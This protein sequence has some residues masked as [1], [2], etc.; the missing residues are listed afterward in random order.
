[1]WGQAEIVDS[2]MWGQAEIVDSTMWGQA[3][4]VDSFIVG[5]FSYLAKMG[6]RFRGNDGTK[7]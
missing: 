7:K 2:T 3:E 4:I 6:S 1:M 5:L